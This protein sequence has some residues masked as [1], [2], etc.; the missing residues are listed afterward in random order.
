MEKALSDMV[1]SMKTKNNTW[2]QVGD[3][4]GIVRS[5][6]WRVAHG[7][8]DS[9]VAREY[10]E[11]PPKRVTVI[12]CDCGE[13]HMQSHPR[14]RDRGR[15]RV[16]LEFDTPEQQ[17]ELIDLLSMIGETRKEQGNKLLEILRECNQS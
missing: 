1:M 9:A 13:V 5:L 12:P 11:L 10:F 17:R 15:Y 8:C 14:T 7:K 6:A 3:T 16:A 4:I 2:Q